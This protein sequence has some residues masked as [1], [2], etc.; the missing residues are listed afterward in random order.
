MRLYLPHEKEEIHYPDNRYPAV[1]GSGIRVLA[2]SGPPIRRYVL[3]QPPFR[4][5]AQPHLQAFQEPST[6]GTLT[7]ERH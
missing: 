5:A 6:G 3:A 1:V 7:V 4:G 2:S